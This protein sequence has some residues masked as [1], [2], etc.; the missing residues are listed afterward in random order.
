LTS[1]QE[2]APRRKPNYIGSALDDAEFRKYVLSELR[3]AALRA[4]LAA[5][6][7]TSI[8]IALKR[9]MIGPRDA[10]E[11]VADAGALDYVQPTAPVQP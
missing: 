2:A 6:D 4:R 11:A 7:I 10:L 1:I 9:G 8:G 3:C 5:N